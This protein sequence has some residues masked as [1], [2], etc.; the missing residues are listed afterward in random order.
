MTASLLIM[1]NIQNAHDQRA[2]AGTMLYNIEESLLGVSTLLTG[3]E[4]QTLQY[5]RYRS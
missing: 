1:K 4:R 3:I 2:Q 5:N